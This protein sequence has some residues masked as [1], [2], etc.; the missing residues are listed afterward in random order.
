[1]RY[2]TLY[3]L[4]QTGFQG[5][6]WLAA[7]AMAMLVAVALFWRQTRRGGRL[8]TH[9]FFVVFCSVALAMGGIQLWDHQRL[10][11]HLQSGSVQV[12]TGPVQ[13]HSV[14]EQVVYNHSSK[15]YD[16]TTWEVFRVGDVAF[17]FSR[18]G[19][20]GFRNCGEQ[21][22]QIHDGQQLR[23]HYVEDVPGVFTERRILRLERLSGHAVLRG[24]KGDIESPG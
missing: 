9:G 22:V 23:L 12:V 15:R 13:S 8:A 5:Q 3:D 4:T 2:E 16:R 11:S 14:T 17:G 24:F 21:L 19:A 6:V 10:V 18:C 7:A 1:M 20:V